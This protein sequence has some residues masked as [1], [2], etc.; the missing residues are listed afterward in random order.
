LPSLAT[1]EQIGALAVATGWLMLTGGIITGMLWSAALGRGFWHNDPKEILAGLT[2]L[3]YTV[4]FVDRTM[5]LWRGRRAAWIGIMGFALVLCTFL[6]ARYLGGYH[7][8]N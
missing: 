4:L 7:V 3:L 2:W 1:V 8:F 6:G 5:R